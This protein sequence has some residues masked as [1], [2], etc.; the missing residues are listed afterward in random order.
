MSSINIVVTHGSQYTWDLAEV[1]TIV[2]ATTIGVTQ[3]RNLTASL[4]P[5]L[6]G[7][8][9]SK[10]STCPVFSH[11]NE[12]LGN[13]HFHMN[14][15]LGQVALLCQLIQTGVFGFQLRCPLSNQQNLIFS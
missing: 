12:K 5:E 9:S 6:P 13:C 1:T 7:P 2:V 15:F 4:A 8:I 3:S 10:I 14:V 11:S